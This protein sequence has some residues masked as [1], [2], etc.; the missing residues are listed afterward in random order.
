MKYRTAFGKKQPPFPGGRRPA[1]EVPSLR[2]RG[3]PPPAA[4]TP[5]K[6][7]FPQPFRRG[8]ARRFQAKTGTAKGFKNRLRRSA[9]LFPPI[10]EFRR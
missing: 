8:G 2:E 5:Q 3:S 6:T 4:R 10:S 9:A 7:G 1:C